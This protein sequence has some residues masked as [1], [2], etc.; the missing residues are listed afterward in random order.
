[1]YVSLFI[2]P[3]RTLI[4]PILRFVER[5]Y[6]GPYT[7]STSECELSSNFGLLFFV[8]LASAHHR[9]LKSCFISLVLGRSPLVTRLFSTVSCQSFSVQS[10]IIHSVVQVP[11]ERVSVRGS[12]MTGLYLF[13]VPRQVTKS[14][15]LTHSLRSESLQVVVVAK[16]LTF[17]H[18]P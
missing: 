17:K 6:P 9:C 7:T 3:L 11:Q 15:R 4:L 12:I 8:N 2:A 14:R 5:G 10:P 18:G 16:F 13:D 1:M